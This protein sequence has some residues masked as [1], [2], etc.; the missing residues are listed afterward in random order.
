MKRPTLSYQKHLLLTP[1]QPLPVV[2]SLLTFLQ[3]VLQELV[4]LVPKESKKTI[5]L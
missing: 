3:V 2:F 4:P 5:T 1:S